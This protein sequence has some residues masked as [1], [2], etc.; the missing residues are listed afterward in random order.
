MKQEGR[1]RL[2][3]VLGAIIFLGIVAVFSWFNNQESIKIRDTR[4]LSD[5]RRLRDAFGLIYRY[6]DTYQSASCQAGDLVSQ[7][8]LEKYLPAISSIKDPGQGQYLVEK[9]P[10]DSGYAVSFSL[11][12]S[13]DGLEAGSHVLSQ[14]GIE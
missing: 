5:I 4:R 7:C 2:D 1:I 14:K 9:T 12:G 8:Q 13:Y 6:E 11:E 3:Y 10:D